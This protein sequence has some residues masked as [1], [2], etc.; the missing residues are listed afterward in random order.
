[1]TS[2]DELFKKPSLPSGQKRKF[3]PVRDPNEIYKSAKLD[4]NGAAS[5]SRAAT[6]DDAE[7]EDIAGPEL[8]PDFGQEDIPDDEEGRFFGGGVTRDTTNALDFIEQQEKEGVT[9]GKIDS[10]WL[11]RTALNF[12]KRI[13]KNAELRAKYESDPQKF[14]ASEADL[15]V[16]IK[17][18]SILS[19]HPQ[20]YPEFAE[21]GC[22]G[23]LV[24]L[25]AHENT[26]IAIDVI[27][28]LAELTDEDV[29]A[30]S[31]QWES[32]V[33]AMLDA[34]LIELLAQN[35][36]RLDEDIESDRA[37]VYHIL[38]VLENLSSQSSVAE[39]IGQESEIMPW[40]YARIQK[41][42]K[43]VTQNK[44][45][46]AEVLA[47]LLQSSQKNRERFAGLNGVDTLLQLLSVYRK[48][49]PEKDSDEEEYV[50]NL[51][52]S[53]TCVVDGALGKEKFVEAE[54]VELAQIMLREGKMSKPRALR[55]LNHAVGGKDGARVCEQ[56][57]EAGLLRTVFGMFMKKQDNQTVEH[58]L[59]IFASLLRLLPGESA[60]RIRT[61]A[62][63][64]EKDYE[65]VSRLVQFRRGYA[66]KL[67]PI[68][69]AIAQERANLS[70]DEQDA[71]AVEWL[72]RRL[73]VGLFSL[74]IIDVILA[75]LVAEDDGA[76]ARIKSLLSDQDQDLSIIRAT[77]EEQLSGLE[78]PEG[79]EEEKDM[80]TT[81]L[82]FI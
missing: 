69:Q 22:V 3:E 50:E 28:I 29:E 66:S 33:D 62:K 42:E 78:G 43:S 63:F 75:W 65:K 15:D 57:V 12:E 77:L 49:D 67:L 70:K 1:M 46:A 82:E 54:G 38:N 24:S 35:L 7:D 10:A 44:Q 36:S 16:D 55:V 73:D 18:L 39:K 68:D 17:G 72:S 64:V 2:I 21:L 56:L 37:G 81:L 47:I 58:L 23:S 60:G 32:L 20:L 30:E 79:E 45:Y 11:K 80:L 40:L 13:S 53:L 59:G 71:M 51:F 76:K 31:E 25:L 14:M 9:A 6:V 4:T 19:E 41:G 8:P 26:D 61:L 34:D 48:R 52:D 27:E 74:Q 5:G